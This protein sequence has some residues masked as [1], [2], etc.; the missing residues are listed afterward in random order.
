[1]ETTNKRIPQIP[2]IRKAVLIY[3]AKNELRTKDIKELF[4]C[5][6][7][8]ATRLKGIA[9]EYIIENDVVRWNADQVNTKAAYE[10]WGL[11]IKDLERRQK[12]L[13][14]LGVGTC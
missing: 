1:M 11:D 2:D 3:Y 6:G 14:E 8:V 5:C 12:K 9:L 4:A 10:S 7:T 13:E